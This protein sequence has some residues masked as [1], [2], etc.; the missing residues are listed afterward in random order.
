MQHHA[1]LSYAKAC[2]PWVR[3]RREKLS[4][5][6]LCSLE[7]KPEKLVGLAPEHPYVGQQGQGFGLE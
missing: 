1:I 3:R 7:L 2:I 4:V 5:V 6:T